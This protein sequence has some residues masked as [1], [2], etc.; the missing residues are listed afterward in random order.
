MSK[1]LFVITQSDFKKCNTP[2][3]IP[4]PSLQIHDNTNDIDILF[5]NFETDSIDIPTIYYTLYEGAI[6]FVSKEDNKIEEIIETNNIII[7]HI[8]KLNE[9][10]YNASSQ[11]IASGKDTGIFIIASKPQFTDTITITS[12]T[13]IKSVAQP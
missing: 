9:L 12:L 5:V 7:K 11:L 3:D 4:T 6:F 1:K 2:H 13:D 10:L 8:I